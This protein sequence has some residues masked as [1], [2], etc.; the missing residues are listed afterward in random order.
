MDA[1]I[2]SLGAFFECPSQLVGYSLTLQK[3]ARLGSQL[4]PSRPPDRR[5]QK[6]GRAPADAQ[7]PAGQSLPRWH[8]CRDAH[9]LEV[10]TETK[11]GANKERWK[12]VAT[13]RALSLLWS[14]MIVETEAELV[15]KVLR[16]GTVSTNV[17]LRRLMERLEAK[18][19]QALKAIETGT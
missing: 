7:S 9:A 12:R 16:I 19:D 1:K 2:P 8:G 13:D 4:R 15:L 11:R 10:L 18:L 14:K 3:S 17:Y 5:C 6:P